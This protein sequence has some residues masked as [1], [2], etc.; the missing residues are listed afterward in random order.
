M[1]A[2]ARLKEL[3][4]K[5][6]PAGKGLVFLA[7]AVL[8][9]GWLLNTPSGI[10]GKADAIGYAVCHRIGERSFHIAG[11]AVSLC[12]RCTGMYLGAVVGM[13]YQS[14]LGRRRTAWPRRGMLIVLGIFF[15]AFGID[16]VNS[17][18]ILFFQK[19]LLYQ[20]HNTL[21]LITGTGMGLVMAITL[22]PAFNQT[23]W[24]AYS[25]RTALET[26]GQFGGLL[27]VS[28]ASIILVLTENPFFLYPLTLVSAGGVVL[29]LAMVYTMALLMLFRKENHISGYR[30]LIFPATGGFLMTMTQIILIDLGRYILTGT[31]DGFQLILG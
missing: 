5:V 9:A 21:R 8:L 23:V 19:P 7:A 12:A 2:K 13:V 24:Q 26:W 30:Q 11:R 14:L 17:A 16:G 31:W 4:T 29:L 18:S 27:G 25:H 20:P 3:S 28:A 1:T 6:K 22:L 10:V 15:I